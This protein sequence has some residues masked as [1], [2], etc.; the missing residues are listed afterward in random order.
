[1]IAAA[2]ASP[3]AR[4]DFSLVHARI[5]KIIEAG[6]IREE[7]IDARCRHAPFGMRFPTP[8]VMKAISA[9]VKKE[10]LEVEIT[11]SVRSYRLAGVQEV[12]SALPA[13]LLGTYVPPPTPPRRPGSDWRCFPS[14][15]G[16]QLIPYRPHV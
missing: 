8:T 14:R 6:H 4:G 3:S 12:P 10:I 11:G 16:S 15:V 9:L 1:M 2:V 7:E 5:I 13:H